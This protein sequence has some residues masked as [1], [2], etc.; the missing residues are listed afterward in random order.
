MRRYIGKSV[1]I[2][3]VLASLLGP[4]VIGLHYQSATRNFRVVREGV[5]YRSGQMTP[6]GLRRMV[7]DYG[8]RTVVSLRDSYTPG[9]LAPDRDEE[10]FCKRL[11]LNY[12]RITPRRWE[13]RNGEPA[14]VEEGVQKFIAIM[15]DARNYPVLV[16]CFGGVHRAGAYSAIYRMEFEGWSNEQAIEELKA[17]GYTELQEHRDILGYMER[18]QPG[19]RRQAVNSR[20]L[21]P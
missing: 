10:K 20:G 14:P 11:G 1:G 3:L 16:H 17:S 21:Q 2:L 5:L 19:W 18:Y 15:A 6:S 4:V 12:H 9:G 13:G 8:I 7:D